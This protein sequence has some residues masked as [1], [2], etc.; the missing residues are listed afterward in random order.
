LTTFVDEQ[1]ERIIAERERQ[2][3]RLAVIGAALRQLL[4]AREENNRTYLPA[5]ALQRNVAAEAEFASVCDSE[6]D[7]WEAVITADADERTAAA[8]EAERQQAAHCD[9]VTV[10]HAAIKLASRGAE[11]AV[12]MSTASAQSPT[13]ARVA[14]PHVEARFKELA[15]SERMN[16]RIESRESAITHWTI[17]QQKMRTSAVLTEDAIR[18]DADRKKHVLRQQ[19]HSLAAVGNV[20]LVSKRVVPPVPEQVESAKG[21][22]VFGSYFD[23]HR[24]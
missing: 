9:S 1:T 18:V 17:W 11:L 3:P 12:V 2:D 24:R 10:D 22:M 7:R 19:I 8:R 13:A 23:S 6:R 4:G 20:V 21:S 16:N 14:W 5:I 15:L